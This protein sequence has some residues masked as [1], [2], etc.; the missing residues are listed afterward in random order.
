L[1]ALRGEDLLA[2]RS[3]LQLIFQDPFDALSPRLSVLELVREPLD[4]QGRGSRAERDAAARTCLSEVRLP[5]S[6]EF[7]SKR[8]HQL[9]GGQLQR[10]AIARA[11]VLRPKVILADEPVSMLDASE[12]ARVLRL[13]K[14][15]QNEHGTGMLL[16]SHDIA[17]V[18]KVADRILVM[19]KGVIVEE[20]L[21]D[22]VINRP[23]HGYT[24]R[25]L[26]AAGQQLHEDEHP[27]DDREEHLRGAT[28]IDAVRA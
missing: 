25:L 27:R 24:R 12:Q 3:R 17:L 14:D 23:R 11:L 10:V 5:T 15:L 19:E 21:A 13:L 20:G 4:I 16:I 28:E 9:S 1:G 6:A 26:A 8:S 7:L 2:A 18:R 22:D